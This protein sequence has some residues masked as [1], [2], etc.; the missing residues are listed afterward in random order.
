[1]SKL[2]SAHVLA[3]QIPNTIPDDKYSQLLKFI[4]KEKQ[5]DI[6]KYLNK[7]DQ[8]ASA[9]GEFIVLS[10]CFQNLN[11]SHDKLKIKKNKFNKPYFIDIDNV[12][13]NISHSGDWVVAIIDKKPVGIDIE[14]I[15][16]IDY[17]LIANNFT[18]YEYF[19]L[20]NSNDPLKMFYEVWT[21]KESYVKALGRGMMI[22]LNSFTLGKNGS[23]IEDENSDLEYYIT[24]QTFKI[25]YKL[26]IASQ[27]KNKPCPIK[28]LI[29]S[30]LLEFITNFDVRKK[31]L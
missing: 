30:E 26:S 14:K 23:I 17:K 27:S 4:S 28:V 13:F 1:M 12:Y 11:I 2:I 8:Y 15:E 7:K 19:K 29:F 31:F 10:Y 18:D 21:Y 24:T 3:I 5:Q 6:K 20:L 25:D 22:P 16:E 9:L